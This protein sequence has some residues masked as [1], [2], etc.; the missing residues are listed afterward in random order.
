MEN[1]KPFWIVFWSI[2]IPVFIPF[3]V[4]F[5]YSK[6]FQ[7][8]PFATGFSSKCAPWKMV[9]F[10]QFPMENCLLHFLFTFCLLPNL[11][12]KI[13]EP[14][15][16]WADRHRQILSNFWST[17]QDSIFAWLVKEAVCE[18]I[19][20]FWFLMQWPVI[21]GVEKFQI[22]FLQYKIKESGQIHCQFWSYR[23]NAYTIITSQKTPH[24][25]IM[26][27]GERA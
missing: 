11:F 6:I 23:F 17:V 8:F 13:F 15:T 1:L 24:Y 22:H 14:L 12:E 18:Q 27:V 2:F 10:H 26:C 4:N 25:S 20:A 16:Q 21:Q 3:M 7:I 19:G 9:D 5:N